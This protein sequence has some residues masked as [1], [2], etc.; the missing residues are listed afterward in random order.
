MLLDPD[1]LEDVGAAIGDEVTV[2]GRQAAGA[3]GG[4]G[5]GVLTDVEGAQPLLGNGAMLTFDGYRRLAPDARRNYFFA[6]FEPGV[7]EREAVASLARFDPLTGAEP[8]DVTNF[9]RVHA[10]PIVIGALLGVTAIA[11]LLHTLISSIRR[12]RRDLAILKVLGFERKQVRQVVAWQATTI[13]AIAVLIGV[14]LGIAA[15]RWGVDDLRR[16]DR[17]CSG[18]RRATRPDARLDSRRP[19]DR[20]PDRGAARR[21]RGAHTARCGAEDR[22]R[23]PPHRLAG[24]LRR[25]IEL[26]GAVGLVA[27]VYVADSPGPRARSDRRRA[28]AALVL[29]A[30]RGGRRAAL[31]AGDAGAYQPLRRGSPTASGERRTRRYAR[32]ATA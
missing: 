7:D 12:R 15:G 20:Q 26:A 19:P 10:V 24:V 14:P 21:D 8:V 6:R 28:D 4:R 1:T 30:C 29:A 22:V 17:R 16:G 3:A 2:D 13:V 27:V 9:G 11:T 18:I 23:R 32:S 25:A 31:R 5:N